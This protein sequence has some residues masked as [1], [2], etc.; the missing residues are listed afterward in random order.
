VEN[1]VDIFMT[2]CIY[3]RRNGTV[4]DSVEIGILNAACEGIT[5]N[6]VAYMGDKLPQNGI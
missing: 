4:L 2:Q 5:V 3:R 6:N 1:V